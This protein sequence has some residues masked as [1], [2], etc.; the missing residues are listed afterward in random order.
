LWPGAVW[1]ALFIATTITSLFTFVFFKWWVFRFNLKADGMTLM[2]QEL[3]VRE[4]S[5]YIKIFIFGCVL[6]SLCGCQIARIA[7]L[8]KKVSYTQTPFEQNKPNSGLKILFLGDSTAVGTG[9]QSNESVAGWFA[10]DYPEADIRNISHNGEK[11]AGLIDTFPASKEHYNLV[12][13]QIGANDIMRLT[14]LKNVRKNLAIAIDRAKA[15]SDHVIM[16]HSADVG[17]APIFVWP[18]KEIYGS[19]SRAVRKIYIEMA[20][21]KGVM[22]VDL[23]RDKEDDLFLK[24][25]KKYYSPDLL[26]FR[27]I[28]PWYN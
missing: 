16:L 13:L 27:C 6:M 19:R 25:I 17:L 23:F 4:T 18:L 3:P 20:H 15:I 21:E 9:A 10:Q 7:S 28:V 11:L 5:K 2:V 24:D 12:V 8:T 1:V 26:H 22:Y 14:L